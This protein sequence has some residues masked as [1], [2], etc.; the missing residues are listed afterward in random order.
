MLPSGTGSGISCCPGSFLSSRTHSTVTPGLCPHT[1]HFWCLKRTSPGPVARARQNQGNA[2]NAAGIGAESSSQSPTTQPKVALLVSPSLTESQ[3]GLGWKG[4][5]RSQI[6]NPPASQGHQPPHLLHQ[7]AQGLIQPGLEHLQG[8]SVP[9]LSGQPVPAPHHSPCKELPPNI[10]PKSTLIQL[11]TVPPC[12]AVIC[13][14]KEFTPFL[15]IDSRF[16]V[17]F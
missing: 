8:R 6:S 15:F 17:L 9:S 5:Q 10:Q 7:V 4:P 11:K 13:P 3:N 16:F 1:A 12:P 2:G 14:F